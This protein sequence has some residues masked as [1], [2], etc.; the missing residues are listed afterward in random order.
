MHREKIRL[1]IFYLGILF[2]V[3]GLPF[4]RALIS[5]GQVTLGALFLFDINLISKLKIFVKDKAAI[6]FVSIYLLWIVGALYSTDF[7]YALFDLRTKL[8]LLIFP[9]VFSTEKPLSNTSYRN[10]AIFFSAV[11]VASIATSLYIYYINN[12]SDYREAFVFVSHIRMSLMALIA[13]TIL[14]YYSISNNDI[15][16]IYRL[17]MVIGGILLI[18]S[19]FI[20]S[21]LS[22]IFI[23]III[24]IVFSIRLLYKARFTKVIYGIAFIFLIIVYLGLSLF[25]TVRNYND[26]SEIDLNNLDTIS[27]QGNK[28]THNPND[29]QI[30]NGSYIGIYIQWY[31]MEQEWTIRSQ[32]DFNGYDNKKQEV[33]ITLL[34]YLNSRGFRKDAQGVKSLSDEDIINIENGIAN[35]E[36]AKRISLKKR[37]YKLIWQ[38][39]IY[40]NN[41]KAQNSGHTILQRLELWQVGIEL[42]SKNPIFGIG[43]GDILNAYSDALEQKSSSLIGKGL[44][45]HNQY[46]NTTITLGFVGLLLFLFSIFYPA[47]I[48]NAYQNPLF[49]YFLVIMVMSMLWED[50]IDS[51]VGVTVYAFFYMFYIYKSKK[52]PI[53]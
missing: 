39:N 40:K 50:T 16:S 46:M 15:K 31:E 11:V 17:F 34:R 10:I 35:Y 44:R 45:S 3:I 13:S 22:G 4:S 43:T 36:Y 18:A 19:Q 1:Y 49:V 38:Y 7:E 23:F 27:L 6:S 26:V 21:M 51:Q 9:L 29:Y 12:L 41:N 48:K 32:M 5:F 20:F 24:L 28:Y 2:T 14:F 52:G 25:S 42:I 37:I 8:P 33:K 53:N 30:E 47:F